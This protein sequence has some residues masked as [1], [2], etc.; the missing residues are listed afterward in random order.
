L[1]LSGGGLRATLFHLGVVERLYLLGVL[2]QVTY[3]SSVSGGAILAGKLATEWHTL[4]SVA[5]SERESTFQRLV[6][7]PIIEFAQYDVRNRA[8]HAILLRPPIESFTEMLHDKL[9]GQTRL[10]NLPSGVGF[11]FNACNL[12][13]GKRFVFTQGYYGDH[14]SGYSCAGWQQIPI[15]TAVA[16]STA[17]PIGFAPLTIKTEGPLFNWRESDGAWVQTAPSARRIVELTD[18]GTYENVGLEAARLHSTELLISSAQGHFDWNEKETRG[19]VDVAVRA[20]TIMMYHY[21]RRIID[22]YRSQNSQSSAIFEVQTPVAAVSHDAIGLGRDVVERLAC[23]RTDLDTFTP[24][25]C[26]LLR[27]QGATLTDATIQR[28]QPHWITKSARPVEPF[29]HQLTQEEL[30][31]LDPGKQIRLWEIFRRP[32]QF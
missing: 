11:G 15:A 17:F 21:A 27:Y 5:D 28:F 23:L 22:D 2:D 12:R 7:T 9:Y 4:M 3:V 30:D 8:L 10:A 26:E 14:A 29:P 18:G 32:W 19:A 20:V 6:A 24:L 1:S 13:N 25:E 31:D 16:A